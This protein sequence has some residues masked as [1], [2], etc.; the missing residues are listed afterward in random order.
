MPRL[1]RPRLPR[2]LD[3]GEEASLVE[4]LD[5]LRRRIF[6]CIGA[7]VIGAV[8]GF[9]ERERLIHALALTIPLKHR[10]LYYFAPAEGFTTTIWIAIYFGFVV[11][12]PVIIWQAWSFFIPAVERVHASMMRWFTLLA[13]LLAVAGI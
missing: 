1:P 4:H 9:V 5:E 6:I 3:H 12:L 7:V 2:R 8:V 11:A 13:S 10:K